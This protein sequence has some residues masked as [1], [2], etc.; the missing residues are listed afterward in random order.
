[1]L[2]QVKVEA[3]LASLIHPPTNTLKTMWDNTKALV[4]SDGLIHTIVE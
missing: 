1:M 3:L 2:S 4:K